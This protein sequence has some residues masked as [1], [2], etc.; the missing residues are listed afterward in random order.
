MGF[1]SFYSISTTYIQYISICFVIEIFILYLQRIYTY[2]N[3]HFKEFTEQEDFFKEIKIIFIKIAMTITKNQIEISVK[4]D[5]SK[6]TWLVQVLYID[7]IF[8]IM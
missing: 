7:N 6:R 2:Y 5:L 8:S 3:E 1:F 4:V